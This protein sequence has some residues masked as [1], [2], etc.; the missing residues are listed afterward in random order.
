MCVCVLCVIDLSP[1]SWAAKVGAMTLSATL[2]FLIRS[3]IHAL[4][5]VADA[6]TLVSSFQHVLRGI[7]DGDI[8]LNSNMATPVFKK[9]PKCL[10][11]LLGTHW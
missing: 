7:C 2:E 8:L 1:N 6:E 9:R 3:R 5:D 10:S 4:L 11:W